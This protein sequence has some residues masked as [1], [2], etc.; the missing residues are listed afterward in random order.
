MSDWFQMGKEVGGA[1]EAWAALYENGKIADAIVKTNPE[2][3]GALGMSPEQFK[4]LSAY[5]KTTRVTGYIKG[6]GVKEARESEQ[7]KRQQSLAQIA[8]YESQTKSRDRAATREA[9]T[10]QFIQNYFTAPEPSSGDWAGEAPDAAPYAGIEGR[11]RWAAERTPGFSAGDLPAA[12]EAIARYNVAVG[13][14]QD[15]T[16]SVYQDEKTGQRFF[17]RGGT[18]LPSGVDPAT[19][20]AGLP[21]APAG[22]RVATM[23]RTP[24]GWEATFERIPGTESQLV[25]AEGKGMWYDPASGKYVK[26]NSPNVW[27]FA[28]DIESETAGGQSGAA[29]RRAVGNY[30]IGTVYKGGLKYLGGDPNDPASWEQVK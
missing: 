29:T 7:L 8:E 25:K 19:A 26:E 21:S 13:K 20:Q 12:V 30:K 27:T 2:V 4:S 10:G 28:S 9:V 17:M 15:A 3:L 23:K 24:R 6:Q 14:G 18:S 22:L 11:M 1:S 5:D 16:P